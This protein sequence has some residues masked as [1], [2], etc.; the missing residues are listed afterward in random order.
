MR[1]LTFF[2]S[3]VI[4]TLC[5]CNRDHPQPFNH[6][7]YSKD[8]SAVNNFWPLHIWKQTTRLTKIFSPLIMH[9]NEA[10]ALS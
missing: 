6:A 1:S 9:P 10:L 4:Q 8:G 5:T 3:Q 7:E 2:S